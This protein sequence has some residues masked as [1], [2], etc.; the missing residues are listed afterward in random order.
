MSNIIITRYKENNIGTWGKLVWDDFVC[1]TFE[2]EGQ[3]ETR[4]NMDRR[5]PQGIYNLRWHQSGKF[6]MLMPNVYNEK[7]PSDRYI[8][9]HPGNYADD[10][11]GC[12]LLG[13]KPVSMGV[14]N[15][16]AVFNPFYSKLKQSNIRDIKLDIRNEF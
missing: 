2:P 9:I 1:H 15:S 8:L 11:Q 5:I 10:T 3:D 12:I 6:G 16:R 4:R 13:N 14:L 7:V